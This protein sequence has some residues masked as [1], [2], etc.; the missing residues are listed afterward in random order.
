MNKVETFVRNP[1]FIIVVVGVA[2]RLILMPTLQQGYD[3][4]YWAVIIRNLESGAGL[5]KVDGYYY[6][7][8][9]G[10]FLGVFSLLMENLSNVEIMGARI[11]D[12]LFVETYVGAPFTATLTTPIF[13]F[14]VKIPFLISDLIVG[15]L[16]Y[17]MV[18]DKTQNIR[19]ATI[20]FALWFLCPAVIIVTSVSGMFD[21]FSVLFILLCFIAIR[22]GQSFLGGALFTIAVMTKFFPIYL[23]FILAMY[24]LKKHRE[25]GDAFKHMVCAVLG[26][27]LMLLIIILPQILEGNLSESFSF[28]TNRAASGGGGEA[29]ILDMLRSRGAIFIYGI[30]IVV[31]AVLALMLYRSK[32]EEL[33]NDLFKYSLIITAFIFLYP[34]LPQ[35]VVLLIAFLVCYMSI[36]NLKLKLSWLLLSIGSAGFVL[37]GN[38]TLLMSLAS[39]TDIIS[40][41]YVSS[42]VMAMQE[43]IFLAFNT[44]DILYGVFAV[45]QS[46]GIVLILRAFIQDRL[47]QRSSKIVADH[48][49]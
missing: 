12:L 34:P 14:I 44:T 6:S 49:D 26:A 33:D 7:P 8:V 27:A 20:G 32:K 21:T 25:D 39:F 40:L 37:G 28:I 18:R 22:K 5:Y 11:F 23:I 10:Y 9:W 16:I 30:S 41:E 45:I 2:I 48:S 15:Y 17:W 46:V 13:N 47:R 31:A 38:F 3:S 1:L 36:S 4:D 35:Y 29:T 24:I 43:P 42:M 19:K